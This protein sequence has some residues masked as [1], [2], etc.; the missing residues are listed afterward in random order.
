MIKGIENGLPV[1]DEYYLCADPHER[2]FFQGRWHDGLLPQTGISEEDKRQYQEFFAFMKTMSEKKGSDGKTAFAIPLDESSRDRDFVKFDSLNMSRF[3]DEKKWTAK[4]LRW[5]VNYCMRD[6]YGLIS[7]NV[8]AWAGIHYFASRS[9]K[10][11]NAGKET[12]LTWPEGNGWL[13]NQLKKKL[14]NNIRTGCLV[15]KITKDG[16]HYLVD[17]DS[18]RIRAKNVIYAGPRYTAKYVIDKSLGELTLPETK[19]APWMV[20]NVTLK[21]LPE[22]KGQDLSWDNVSYYSQSLGYIVSTHQ[23]LE[24]T[25]GESVIT[26]YLPLTAEDADVA[27]KNAFTKDHSFWAEL[28]ADDLEKMHPGI[29]NEIL[30][31]DVCIWGHGMVGPVPGYLWGEN[32]RKMQA[33]LGGIHFA[34]TDMSGVSIFEEAQY[35]GIM[36][37]RK[38]L[39]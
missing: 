9:G 28:A 2:L 33:S 5:Y 21:N 32:R 14:I 39:G 26:Y 10:A 16:D 18:T 15:H 36:A 11:A 29:K 37:A 20:A 34:H 38:V 8:S 3:M 31:I 12:V 4:T 17:F 13:V 27:R 19:F 25:P 23:K 30:N 24:R 6:D 1:Y 22:G 35:R 7:E